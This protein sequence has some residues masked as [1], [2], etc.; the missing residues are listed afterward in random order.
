VLAQPPHD[1]RDELPGEDRQPE[2][3]QQ[4][5]RHR[6]EHVPRGVGA[7]VPTLERQPAGGRAPGRWLE[8][9]PLDAEVPGDAPGQPGSRR[10]DA[11]GDVVRDAGEAGGWRHDEMG[12]ADAAC[13]AQ[14]D[15]DDGRPFRGSLGGQRQQHLSGA[16]TP[17]QLHAVGLQGHVR[18]ERGA[19]QVQLELS[20]V[21][22]QP[23]RQPVRR[24]GWTIEAHGE[25]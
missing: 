23:P 7:R 19:Q 18:R 15:V 16:G 11:A 22:R 12:P 4:G 13:P 24:D 2:Q 25:M 1:R 8:R 10:R 14:L 5:G 17:R 9:V 20:P 3:P 21:P 6:A